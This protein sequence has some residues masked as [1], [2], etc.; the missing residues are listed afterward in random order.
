MSNQTH[1]QVAATLGVSVKAL[2]SLSGN[3]Q[4]PR[5]VSGS[6]VNVLWDGGAIRAF[7]ALW[8]AAKSNGWRLP[9]AIVPSAN[10]TA[11]AAAAP[12]SHYTNAPGTDPLFDDA[13]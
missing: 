6:D 3:T 2:W 13:P 8:N 11:M 12:G 7:A 1:T 10:F 5:P 9:N 4:F